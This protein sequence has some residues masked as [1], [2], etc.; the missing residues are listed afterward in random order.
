MGSGAS[1]GRLRTTVGQ[2]EVGRRKPGRNNAKPC[3]VSVFAVMQ[4]AAGRRAIRAGSRRTRGIAARRSKQPAFRERH[5][6]RSRDDE[7]VQYPHVDQ[8]ERL[9]QA[10]RQHL[11]AAA[12]FGHARGAVVGEDD[13]GGIQRQ[14]P[15]DDLARVDAGLGRRA[16]EQF[17]RDQQAILRIEEQGDEHFVFTA[18]Q[19]E[20]QVVAHRASRTQR[21]IAPYVIPQA[22]A[23]EFQHGLQLCRLGRTKPG[24]LCQGR[25][26]RRQQ[27]AESAEARQGFTPEVQRRPPGGS[28]AQE[29]S[30]QLR[31]GQHLRPMREQAFARE[32]V[33]RPI[34][35]R[36]VRCLD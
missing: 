23:H 13:C 14:R 26:R 5:H 8:G 34:L 35:D 25:G 28:G 21:G 15:L 20:A 31:I 9:A 22:A 30:D 17:L 10:G 2:P 29:Q 11:V 32:L 1:P 36:H 19:C 27:A 24:D 4:Q 16:A 3:I 6:S 12:G 33:L 18:A 7:V